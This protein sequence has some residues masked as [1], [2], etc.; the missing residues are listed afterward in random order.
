[1]IDINADIS[2]V[3][4]YVDIYFEQQ[5]F[6]FNYG[7]NSSRRRVPV[8][9]C[10]QD[11]FGQDEIDVSFFHSWDGLAVI[12]ADFSK[13]EMFSIYNDDLYVIYSSVNINFDLCNPNIS[14]CKNESEI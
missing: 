14:K 10:T 13:D 6:D 7:S 8:K 2:N 12:C 3:F 1:M 4:Q 9:W 5:D 11:D